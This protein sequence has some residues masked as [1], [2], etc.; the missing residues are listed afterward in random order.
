MLSADAPEQRQNCIGFTPDEEVGR[1]VDLFDERVWRGFW[2]HDRRRVAGEIIMR[3][4]NAASAE[5]HI[6][7][8]QRA[9]PAAPRKDGQRVLVAMELHDLLPASK[10]RLYGCV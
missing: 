7:G 8:V 9:L 4:S 6:K 5:V 10:T 3:G 2:L 1:G